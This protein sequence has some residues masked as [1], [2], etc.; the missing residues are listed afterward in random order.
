MPVEPITEAIPADHAEAAFPDVPSEIK[1]TSG[2][3][4]QEPSAS[5]DLGP[6]PIVPVSANFEHDFDL[7]EP[8]SETKGWVPFEPVDPETVD[9][10]APES[11][12][13][14]PTP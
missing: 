1:P 5:L 12:E 8:D 10:Q 14:E 9:L 13:P 7:P 6:E 3:E 2:T 4:S 11:T